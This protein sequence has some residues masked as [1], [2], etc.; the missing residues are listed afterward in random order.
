MPRR[1]RGYVA[2]PPEMN[3]Q[4]LYEDREIDYRLQR[5]AT[6]ERYP[7]TK[8]D[9]RY[10]HLKQHVLRIKAI[11][12][13]D[14]GHQQ[15]AIYNP[16]LHTRVCV[17]IG[18]KE[19]LTRVWDCGIETKMSC[20]N[21]FGYIWLYCTHSHGTKFYN[22]VKNYYL[23]LGSLIDIDEIKLR[24]CEDRSGPIL[25]IRFPPHH[26]PYVYLAFIIKH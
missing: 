7:D 8:M 10:P 24:N 2:R 23:Q 14:E 19:L 9:L 20:Q 3:I 15:V 25:H 6:C 4:K 12:D 17:D 21:S 16:F 13:R 26:Y 11:L 1:P 18:M 22:I 5:V